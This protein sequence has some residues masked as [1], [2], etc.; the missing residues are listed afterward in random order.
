MPLKMLSEQIQNLGVEKIEQ[1]LQRI[2]D[3]PEFNAAKQ[4]RKFFQFVVKETLAGKAQQIKAYT[5]ATRVFGRRANFD[6]SSDPIVSVQANNLRRA[7]ERYYLIAGKK[8]HVIIDIP[9]GTYV[10]VFTMRPQVERNKA[11]Y[12]VPE[13]EIDPL[14]SQPSVL[15]RPFQNMTG[16]SEMAYLAAGLATELSMELARCQELRVLV[17]REGE[18][19]K[20]ST[21]VRTR[22]V[23]DGSIRSDDTT[24]KVAVQLIDTTMGEQ[25]WGDMFKSPIE[26]EKMIAFQENVAMKISSHIASQ[27]GI[28]VK[29]LSQESKSL[30]ICDLTAY[31]A[32]LKYY[33]YQR[34]LTPE[35]YTQAF[36]A[37]TAAIDIEPGCGRILG[38][39]ACLYADNIALEFFDIEQ[40]PLDKAVRMAQESV[41]LE[42]NNQ[43]NRLVLGHLRLLNNEMD[44]S[45]TEIETA[46]DLNPN[47]LFFMD[48]IGYALTLLGQWERGTAL[49]NTAI[50]LNP[51]YRTYAR[52]GNWLNWFRLKEYQKAY[53]ETH[54]LRGVGDFWDPLA[55]A[56]TLG[57]LGEYDD[58]RKAVDELLAFKPDFSKRVQMLIN[59]FVK[60]EE[61]T[62]RIVEGLEK[63]GLSIE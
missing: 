10:P 9:T 3:S 58:G 60:F 46:M 55:R 29:T 7:L 25:I 15:I 26:S 53:Q 14:E 33:E 21:D 45:L 62:E 56:A 20:R 27:N 18:Y 39:L 1:Q 35:A 36:E 50:E 51:F 17:Y 54:L 6:Q 2:L 44:I 5:I 43:H 4:Q 24:T 8:D 40:T 12:G 37:L 16:N 32:V 31:Q 28:I 23:I 57:Q 61:I 41:L 11:A 48:H 13:S 19:G 30:P 38:A 63:V 59:H 47:S 49:I 42:P 22:F 34:L 52:Y